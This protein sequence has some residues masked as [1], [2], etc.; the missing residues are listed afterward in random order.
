[1][2]AAYFPQ[3][4]T[5]RNDDGDSFRLDAY[6][7]DDATNQAGSPDLKRV[8][9]L[10]DETFRDAENYCQKQGVLPPVTLNQEAMRI[11]PG[12][13]ESVCDIWGQHMNFTGTT[14][15]VALFNGG[16]GGLGDGIMFSAALEVLA[17]KLRKTI[18]NDVV[19][20]V[21]SFFPSRTRA[22]LRGIP[23]VQVKALPVS[24]ADYVQYDAQVDFSSMLHSPTFKTSHMTDFVLER[25]GISPDAV[26]SRDKEPVLRLARKQNPIVTVALDRARRQSGK[27][28][29]VA[30]IFSS[31]RIRTLPDFKAVELFQLLVPEYQ[32]VL[33]MPPHRDSRLFLQENNLMGS[34]IDLSPVSTGF[35][36]YLS[37]LSGMDAVISVDTSAVHIG[38]ALRLPTVGIFNSINKDNRICYSPT[39]VGIQL[40]YKGKR[41]TA[42]CGQSKGSC[43]V[44]GEI[45]G[46]ETVCLDFGYACDEA[47]DKEMLL[48]Q[49]VTDLRDIDHSTDVDARIDAVY[50]H[51][52]DKFI[53]NFPP[54]WDVLDPRNVAKA[55]EQASK[56]EK[57]YCPPCTCPVCGENDC[58]RMCDRQQGIYRYR[59]RNCGAD[60][61]RNEDGGR[62][63][64]WPADVLVSPTLEE[65]SCLRELLALYRYGSSLFIATGIKE[66][67]SWWSLESELC[68]HRE[69]IAENMKLA[70]KAFDCV[71]VPAVLD[72]VQN[73]FGIFLNIIK[74]LKRDGYLIAVSLNRNSLESNV[75]DL[76]GKAAF[77][78]PG[79]SWQLERLDIFCER[80]GAEMVWRG[81]SSLDWD[82]FVK[83][84]GEMMSLVIRPPELPNVKI[85][86]TGKDLSR[87]VGSRLNPA[88]QEVNQGRFCVVVF[89]RKDKTVTL[90][91]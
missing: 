20:D 86:L 74:S 13:P 2:I 85:E 45:K 79:P 7:P 81:V 47:V 66:L 54:C 32:P 90:E 65:C 80:I 9:L 1:M 52:R 91:S 11:I 24:I 50:Q 71:F 44:K 42:P 84:A 33:I 60:F 64:E 16:G 57:R 56:L 70:D 15:R 10:L 61:F 39:V 34:V 75:A 38:G 6:T 62:D 53:R 3:T 27:R 51:Y 77:F 28:K 58:H 55:L 40:A 59:C 89:R 29:L 5:V 26:P 30:V 67:D 49:V 46:R 36:E 12:W 41:C 19:L 35:V 73:P 43:Y 63:Y 48:D 78:W 37:L 87:T 21:F 72:I 18:C 23:H 68:S 82:G 8:Y 31:A 14:F 17:G 88:L 83:A 76:A 69:V 22:V 4:I 25:M